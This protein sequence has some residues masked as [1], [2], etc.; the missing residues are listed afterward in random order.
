MTE[1][2]KKFKEE[3]GQ[4]YKE[5]QTEQFDIY[6]EFE[7][8]EGVATMKIGD[9]VTIYHDPLIESDPEGEAEL[10]QCISDNTGFYEGRK[11]QRWIVK[12][13]KG[14]R[15]YFYQRSILAKEK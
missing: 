6:R 5:F 10:T 3:F 4:D 7:A 14:S 9:I 15:T 1:A 8:D 11:L 2:E 13:T 12:F